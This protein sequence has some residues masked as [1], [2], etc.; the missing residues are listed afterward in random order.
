[1]SLSG[2]AHTTKEVAVT[3]APT[4]SRRWRSDSE[5][6]YRE[7]VFTNLPEASLRR[8]VPVRPD[9]S[10]DRSRK[11]LFVAVAYAETDAGLVPIRCELDARSLEDAIRATPGALRRSL[12]EAFP[13][14]EVAGIRLYPDP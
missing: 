9:G 1:M 11:T 8:L 10:P 5:D 2:P 13:H 12:A 4:R 14:R 3:D 7:E 6:L